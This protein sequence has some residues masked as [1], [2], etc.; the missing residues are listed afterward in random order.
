MK[1][2]F[3]ARFLACPMCHSERLL[4][5]DVQCRGDDMESGSIRCAGC[6][7]LF[8][9][10][11]GIPYLYSDSVRQ[12]IESGKA[13]TGETVRRMKE[14]SEDLEE[15]ITFA[16][17]DYHNRIADQ[18]ERDISTFGMFERGKGSQVRIERTVKYLS[19]RTSRQL[20]VDTGCGTGNILRFATQGFDDAIGVDVSAGMLEIAWRRGLPVM[21][22]DANRLPLRSE[23]ADVVSAFSVLHHCKNPLSLLGESLRVLR[24]G[25]FIYTDWDPNA[26]ASQIVGHGSRSRLFR[27]LR[28]AALN[29][30]A[31]LYRRR[32][33]QNGSEDVRAIGE[34]AE[35]HHGQE[36]GLD[37][38]QLVEFMEGNGCEKVDIYFH[39]NSDDLFAPPRL[40]WITRLAL[41]MNRRFSVSDFE[42]YAPYFALIGQKG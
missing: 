33:V 7:R 39:D 29:M 8:P 40:R 28:P 18:Y 27:R 11:G 19:T 36:S 14:K 4:L 13:L 1:R 24:P 16:N 42:T 34:L 22:A 26:K 31:I 3:V 9:I 20:W 41:L 25:G 2:D 38:H 17:I 23:S 15:S 21:L 37:P 6:E 10:E 32:R 12:F 5:E 30:L 35:Y